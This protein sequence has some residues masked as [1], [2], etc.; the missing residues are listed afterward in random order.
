[1]CLFMC[2]ELKKPYT[3]HFEEIIHVTFQNSNSR[4]DVEGLRN[5]DVFD[6][7]VEKE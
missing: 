1:M 2:P 5:A 7:E 6:P 4:Q 3:L